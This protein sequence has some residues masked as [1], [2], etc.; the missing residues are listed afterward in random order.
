ME[1]EGASA[2]V[3]QYAFI[4]LAPRRFQPRMLF[5]LAHEI[6]HL[7][8]R[9]HERDKGFA[10]YDREGDIG[11]WISSRRRAE[12]FADGFATALLLPRDAVARVLRKVRDMYALTG[13]LGDIEINYLA[14]F[15]G[16]SFEVAGRRCEA[17]DLLP[18]YGARV[19]YEHLVKSH[20][21]PERR[22]DE[23]GL[24]PRAKIQFSVS[25]HL[26][27]AARQKLRE[28]VVSIGNVA[29]ALHLPLESLFA[30][31]IESGE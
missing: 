24:P 29:E 31:N 7:L 11:T 18:K 9:H 20:T 16:V 6:G 1:A 10:T 14:R 15:F 17:L 19:L 3:E 23:V 4:F 12:M 30:A 2:L 21:N 28:G 22:A 27:T 26:L 25:T 5:T 13:P 8:A